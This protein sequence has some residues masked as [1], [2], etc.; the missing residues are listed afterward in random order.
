MPRLILPNCSTGSE[1]GTGI[2]GGSDS[3]TLDTNTIVLMCFVLVVAIGLCTVYLILARRF[4]KSF[5]WITGI[6]NVC[7]GFG[8]GRCMAL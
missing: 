2:Y 8:M 1:Q 4:T 5:I 7:S 6:L 3:L